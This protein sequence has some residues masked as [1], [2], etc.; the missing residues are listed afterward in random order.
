VRRGYRGSPEP[1]VEYNVASDVDA[2]RRAFAAG[3]EVTLTPLDTCGTVYLEGGLYRR[4]F[5]CDAPL[6][7]ALIENYR[8]WS[9][10]ID[11][12]PG[13]FERRSTTLYDT[14]AVWL[15]ISEEL[16]VIE[17][18]PI[19]VDDGGFTRV[20]ESARLLRVATEWRDQERFRELLVERLA[21]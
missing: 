3:W 12:K 19:R 7:R 5:E 17:E 13:V 8:V 4:V 15:A 16:L 9:E 1:A 14:V 11:L 21:G 6:T 18:L 2:C 10:A 20:A